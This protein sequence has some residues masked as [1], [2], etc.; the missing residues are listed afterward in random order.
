MAHSIRL[1]KIVA[2]ANQL[3]TQLQ[4]LQF[5]SVRLPKEVWCPAVNV[6]AYEDRVEVCVELSGVAQEDISVEAGV[7][8]LVIYGRRQAPEHHC[9]KPRCRRILMMEIADGEFVRELQLPVE[10]DPDRTEARQENGW[11]W[12]TLPIIH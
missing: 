7:E 11:L 5:S 10:I 9:E 6:Y 3:A 12:I 8:R 4:E 2:R 1:T